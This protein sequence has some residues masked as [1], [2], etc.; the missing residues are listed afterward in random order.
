VLGAAPR[1]S[2]LATTSSRISGI[3]RLGLVFIAK[4]YVITFLRIEI[5]EVEGI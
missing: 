2:G 5:G 4:G 3:E 1:T